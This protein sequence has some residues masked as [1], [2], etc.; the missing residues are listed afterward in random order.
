MVDGTGISCKF[1]TLFQDISIG[2]SSE[3]LLGKLMTVRGMISELY[4]DNYSF[5]NGLESDMGHHMTAFYQTSF[6]QSMITCWA[7][8]FRAAT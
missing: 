8:R 3:R 2:Y 4:G 7:C 6:G 5:M 1:Q